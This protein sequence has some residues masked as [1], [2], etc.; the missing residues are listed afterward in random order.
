MINLLILGCCSVLGWRSARLIRRLDPDP[1]DAF[2]V[3]GVGLWL[4]GVWDGFAVVLLLVILM[5]ERVTDG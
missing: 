1:V 4:L 3:G 5:A 2:L